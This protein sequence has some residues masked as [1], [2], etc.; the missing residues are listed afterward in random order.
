[1]ALLV[2]LKPPISFIKQGTR[3]LNQQ[4]KSQVK[5]SNQVL[6]RDQSTYHSIEET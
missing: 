1:M 6:Q 3:I 2:A 5:E 4:R